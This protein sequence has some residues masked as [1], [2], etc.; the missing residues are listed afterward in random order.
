[1]HEQA[2]A[3]LTS[4]QAQHNELQLEAVELRCD[5]LYVNNRDELLASGAQIISSD[6]SQ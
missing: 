2:A 3:S 5:Q 4:L 6:V 1:M